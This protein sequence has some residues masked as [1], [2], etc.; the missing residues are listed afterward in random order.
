LSLRAALIALIAF[1]SLLTGL[2]LASHLLLADSPPP[3]SLSANLAFYAD[4]G[5]AIQFCETGWSGAYNGAVTPHCATLTDP[6]S[7]FGRGELLGEGDYLSITLGAD[8]LQFDQLMAHW[9]MPRLSR[10]RQGGLGLVWE[11]PALQAT[12]S[13]PWGEPH[14]TPQQ[15]ILTLK[16]A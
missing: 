12:A 7:L 4:C 14:R 15:A 1:A 5:Y 3:V 8:A 16:H 2:C 10:E 6:Q 11:L 13:L 9:G